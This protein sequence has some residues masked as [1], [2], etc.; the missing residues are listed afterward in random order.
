M[1][2]IP[3]KKIKMIAIYT[4]SITLVLALA[5]FLFLNLNP[6][7]G[8]KV[9]KEQKLAFEK[10]GYFRNGQFQNQILTEMHVQGGKLLKE[11]FFNKNE[12]SPENGLQVQKISR[13]VLDSLSNQETHVMWFGH[14]TLLIK[15]NGKLVLIDPMLGN[16]PSPVSFAGT[17]RFSKDLPI[18]A[19]ELP[20]LD[21]VLISH[22]H[23]DHLDYHTILSIKEKTKLFYAPLGVN[24]HLK[25][26]GVSDEKIIEAQWHQEFWLDSIQFIYTPSRHFS[27]RGISDRNTTLWG[28]WIIRNSQTSIYF[29]GDGGYGP[30]FKEIGEKY[31]PFDLV[32]T[33][34]G[35]YNEQWQAIHML[36]EESV[37]ASAD[38]KAKYIM[39]VHWGAFTLALHSWTEPIEK[40][41]HKANELNIP[42]VTPA[43]GQ[44]F[45]IKEPIGEFAQW[46]KQ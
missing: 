33:E 1:I 4:L 28:G 13:E 46:W 40:A 41:M 27:G 18:S 25:R 38:A 24:N 2:C 23:Y 7:F 35:Q 20:A 9:T 8:G 39:P 29:T 19:E 11:M 21:A 15:I 30:H 5:V 34:C 45:T 32:L 16:N 44:I 22:D 17:K 36:P 43:I 3:M 26:W 37:Q 10:T 12:R 42:I 31:G 14:S 6:A